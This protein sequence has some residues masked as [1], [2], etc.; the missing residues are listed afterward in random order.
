MPSTCWCDKLKAT[1]LADLLGR[2]G[3]CE[4][5]HTKKGDVWVVLH[6][7]VLSVSNFLSQYFGGQ[8]I[9]PRGPFMVSRKLAMKDEPN[10]ELRCS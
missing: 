4:A 6:G 10:V 8:V 9:P 1:S 7:R 3:S 5:K 2:G